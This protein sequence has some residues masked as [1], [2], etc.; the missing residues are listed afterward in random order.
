MVL[1]GGGDAWAGPVGLV[2]V[3]PDHNFRRMRYGIGELYRFLGV[4]RRIRRNA[5]LQWCAGCIDARH[6]HVLMRHVSIPLALKARRVAMFDPK[7]YPEHRAMISGLV[8]FG[9]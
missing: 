3:Q 8:C 5:C 4:Q 6:I 1:Y 9:C 7:Q 2:A